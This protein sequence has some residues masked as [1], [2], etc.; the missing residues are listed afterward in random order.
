MSRKVRNSRKVRVRPAQVSV[1]VQLTPSVSLL[2][3]D[4]VESPGLVAPSIPLS[5]ED[6]AASRHNPPEMLQKRNLSVHLVC[7]QPFSHTT[8]PRSELGQSPTNCRPI[9][10][11]QYRTVA[12]L[13]RPASPSLS[14]DPG[15]RRFRHFDF[16][17][18]L[19][20]AK[21]EI[22]AQIR[23]TV[24]PRPGP[25]ARTLQNMGIERAGPGPGARSTGPPR[26]ARPVDSFSHISGKPRKG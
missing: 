20:T 24:S 1:R 2:S 23:S 14:P 9:A 22:S 15:R 13:A 19:H 11:S 8:I 3:R 18:F 10:A 7:R 16:L 6:R 26:R 5:Q 21:C 4:R 17:R 12:D 25:A